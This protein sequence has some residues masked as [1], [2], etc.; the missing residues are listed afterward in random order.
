MLINNKAVV[1][2]NVYSLSPLF[3][4]MN[5]A[6]SALVALEATG[7]FADVSGRIR[8]KMCSALESSQSDYISSYILY[9]RYEQEKTNQ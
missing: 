8:G 2:F 4:H 5:V 3:K 7:L 6:W 1:L 9:C